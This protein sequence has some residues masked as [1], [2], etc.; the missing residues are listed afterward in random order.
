MIGRPH[1]WGKHAAAKSCFSRAFYSMK[2]FYSRLPLLESSDLSRKIS[3]H[4]KYPP[5]PPCLEPSLLQQ[6]ARYQKIIC[7]LDAVL[8][9]CVW[10]L[11]HSASDTRRKAPCKMKTCIFLYNICLDIADRSPGKL[12]GIK[13]LL[14]ELKSH[15]SPK[16]IL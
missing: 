3:F 13:A 1:F 12:S 4:L 15:W 11:H 10:Q 14:E 2:W 9:W 5:P 7:F 16:P 8:F 6:T